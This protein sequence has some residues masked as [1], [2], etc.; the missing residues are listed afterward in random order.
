MNAVKSMLIKSWLLAVAA[1]TLSA[2]AYAEKS[3][4]ADADLAALQQQ[5]Q[6][7]LE[8]MLDSDPER[9]AVLR[10]IGYGRKISQISET[11]NGLPYRRDAHAKATG[12]LRA[13]FSVRGDIPERYQFGVFSEPT[14][15]YQAWIRFSNGDMLVQ[16]DNKPDARGMAIKVMG[17]EGQPIAPELAGSHPT[18]DFIMTNT[19]AFFHRDIFDYVE[20]MK[21]LAELKR[22]RWFVSLFPPRLHP[23]RFYRAVQTVSAKISTPLKPQYYSMLPYRIGHSEVKFSA[24]PC[25]GMTFPDKVDT[26]NPDYLTEAMTGQLAEGAACFDFMLQARKPGAHMPLDDATVIWSEAESPFVPVARVSIPPQAFDSEA[27]QHFCENLSMNPW[28]GVGEWEPLGSLSRARRV[29]YSAVSMF[30]HGKNGVAQFEPGSWCI[31][32]DGVGTQ[33]CNGETFFDS[34]GAPKRQ[35]VSFDSNYR[36]ITA[37]DRG[38]EAQAEAGA[39]T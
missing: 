30:R 24:R 20:D 18:Q 25:I 16:P 39:E 14:R 22:T 35:G 15:E 29:V 23:K 28:H 12:C 32:G 36:P 37:T 34:P 31:A 26:E 2:V 17:V 4:E 3:S 1:G 13:T 6:P 38:D 33:P 8:E 5:L 10:A 7:I 27:Q 21:Y 11:H 19:P 9:Q